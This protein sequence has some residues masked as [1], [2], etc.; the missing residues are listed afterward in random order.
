MPDILCPTCGAALT[1]GSRQW[2]CPKGHCFDVARQGYVNLLPVTQK[3]SRQPGDTREQVVARRTF[4]EAG[5]YEPLAQAV[6]QAARRY[7]KN[8][9]AIL[10]AGLWRGLLQ[11]ADSQGT[12]PGSS[13]RSGHLQGRRASGCREVQVRN[14][15]L[16][17]GGSSALS[18]WKPGFDFEYVCADCARGV[19]PGFDS[20]RCIP[21]GSGC[22]GSSAGI[23]ENHLSGAFAPAEG[24]LSGPSRLCSGG[25]LP[26]LLFPLR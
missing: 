8:A 14:L 19:S 21:S 23:E 7:G 2:L 1:L 22:G 24:C 16:R 6:C 11:R 10:D 3:H 4:L 17:N 25:T 18:L 26:D 12:A 5:F 9:K 15:D 13:I 20:R